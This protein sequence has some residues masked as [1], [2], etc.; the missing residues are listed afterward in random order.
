[1]DLVFIIMDTFSL[2]DELLLKML[3]FKFVMQIKNK[4]NNLLTYFDNTVEHIAFIRMEK[5]KV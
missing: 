2:V 5:K 1:M 3:F 4:K